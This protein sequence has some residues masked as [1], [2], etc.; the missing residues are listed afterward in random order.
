MRCFRRSINGIRF[1]KDC[2]KR[3]RAKW[4]TG[5]L[6]PNGGKHLPFVVV[7]QGVQNEA[8]SFAPRVLAHDL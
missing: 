6:N 7:G 4:L 1:S 5:F 2:R 3:R 8:P